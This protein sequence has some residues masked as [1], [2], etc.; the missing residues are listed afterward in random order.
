M[1]RGV[2]GAI[3]VTENTADAIL[4]AVSDLLSIMIDANQ[5]DPDDVGCVFFT[6][7]PDLNAEFP[8]VAARQLGWLDVA[9]LCGHEMDVPHGLKHCLRILIMWNTRLRAQD[10]QHI[11]L[12]DAI[13]LRPDRSTSTTLLKRQ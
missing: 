9:I 2:R 10:I 3:T 5:I 13:S 12:G 8:A 1:C 11:Y 6:T 4:Q 7:T